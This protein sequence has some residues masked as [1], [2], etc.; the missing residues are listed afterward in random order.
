MAL[1]DWVDGVKLLSLLFGIMTGV[2]GY[3][4]YTTVEKD[5]Q[6]EGARSQV[7]NVVNHY[8]SRCDGEQGHTVPTEG[9]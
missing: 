1:S 6:L 8:Y 2:A 3:F 4:G 9:Q 7:T 5:Q